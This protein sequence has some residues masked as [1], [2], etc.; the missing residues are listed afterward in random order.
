MLV[1][2]Q[3][4]WRVGEEPQLAVERAVA[5]EKT[6]GTVRQLAPSSEFVDA[7]EAE[8]HLSEP[9]EDLDRVGTFSIRA[10]QEQDGT[11]II[12]LWHGGKLLRRAHIGRGHQEPDNGPF[13]QGAHIHFPTTIFQNMEGRRARTRVYGW[14][15]SSSISL[16]DALVTFAAEINLVGT[17]VT[18][19]R[20]L[21][22]GAR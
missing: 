20:R 9:A 18:Q 12:R 7:Y 8:L 13:F 17:P 14:S 21:S 10:H 19:Q 11:I 22:G 2:R 6:W 1:Q 16:W 15:V 5:A 3:A 4:H